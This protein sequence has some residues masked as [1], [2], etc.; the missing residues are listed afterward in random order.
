MAVVEQAVQHGTD[1]RYIAQHLAPVFY[2]TI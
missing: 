1:R 2:W